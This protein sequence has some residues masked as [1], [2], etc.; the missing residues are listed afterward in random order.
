MYEAAMAYIQLMYPTYRWSQVFYRTGVIRAGQNVVSFSHASEGAKLFFLQTL[1]WDWT[2]ALVP[3]TQVIFTANGNPWFT[4]SNIPGFN[5][6]Q[7]A[8][9]VIENTSQLQVVANTAAANFTMTVG[10]QYLSA[11]D[12][13]EKKAA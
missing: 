7:S 6:I 2:G 11:P 13:K 4:Q 8:P 9:L 5:I 3:T 12:T 10:Y 1:Q